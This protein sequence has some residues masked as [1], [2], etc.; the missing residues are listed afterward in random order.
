MKA[1]SFQTAA[2]RKREAALCGRWTRCGAAGELPGPGLRG[3]HGQAAM[4]TLLGPQTRGAPALP[5]SGPKLE[6]TGFF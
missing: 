2:P 6:H 3:G 4:G 1:F 5:T